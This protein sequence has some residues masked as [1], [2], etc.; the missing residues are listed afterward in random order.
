MRIGQRV[1]LAASVAALLFAHVPA[2]AQ[3]TIRLLSA[4]PPNT[5]MIQAGE[6]KYIAAVEA[7]SN[8]EI[9]VV[10]NGPETVPPFQQLQ[11]LSTGVFHLMYTTPAYHQADT[12]MGSAIDG[13]LTTDSK[14]L[15][16]SG[17]MDWL[18]AYYRKKF[19][20]VIL[21]LFACPPNQFILREPLPADGTL[22]GR[23]LR[24]N[25]AFEGIVRGLGGSP[26]G[27]PPS[28]VYSAM[29]KG[30]IDGTA[31]PQHAAADY[32]FYEVGKFMTRP[33][34]GHTTLILMA[35]AA[36][37][38]ALPEKVR[39]L[40][41]EEAIRMETYGTEEMIAITAKQNETMEQKGVKVVQFPPEV[42]AKLPQLFAEG[43]LAVAKKSDGK[44]VDEMVEFA[45]QKGALAVGNN[46]TQ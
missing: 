25:A 43:T 41:Q 33:G 44:A 27:L 10:R 37:F 4:W 36:A 34:Y 9:K 46:A 20:V 12:G 42:A 7:A 28:D 19:G 3:T 13:L 14:K 24:T 11:P 29:E 31:A 2:Q 1:L 35:N 40:L 38:D 17:M 8:R 15:R 32:R 39:K 23:K 30:V 18:N 45:R 21:A 6:S 22:K 5:S 16:E 26:V